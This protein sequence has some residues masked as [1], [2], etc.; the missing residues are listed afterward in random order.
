MKIM[1]N[2]ALASLL[3]VTAMPVR[4]DV[5]V[6]VNATNPTT[7]SADDIKRILLGRLNQFPADGVA[8]PMLRSTRWA[9]WQ[10]CTQKFLGKTP[11][12]VERNWATRVFSGQS[13]A[14]KV[15]FTDAEAVQAV[16]MNPNAITCVAA[17]A[18]KGNSAVRIVAK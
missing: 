11:S 2:L 1:K 16:A 18:V 12:D 7:A 17:D 6:I 13:E 8:I 10:E 3:V 4:A 15:I 14:P 5:V 9:L